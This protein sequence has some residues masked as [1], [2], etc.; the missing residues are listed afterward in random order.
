MRPLACITL[1]AIFNYAICARILGLF[2]HPGRSHHMV[3][4]SLLQKL[5]ERGHHVTVASFFP[6]KSPPA[7]YTDVSFEGITKIGLETIDLN[8]YENPEFILR[9]P[10]IG[11]IYKQ[12]IDFNPLWESALSVCSKAIDWPPLKEAL[13]KEYDVVLVE[14]FNSDCMIGLLHVYQIKAPVVAMLS[15]NL[16]PWSHERIGAPDNPSYVPLITTTFTSRMTFL[17]RMENTFLKLYLNLFYQQ[18]IQMKE[19]A[20]IEKHYGVKIP[21]LNELAKNISLMLT[22]THHA[23]NGVRPLVPGLVEVGGM[24]F[25]PTKKV[26]PEFIEKFLNESEHGVIIF[27]F[28]SLIKTATMPKY[29]EEIFINALSKL[30][31]RV[32][33]KFE[34]SAEEGTLVGNILKVKWLPQYELL[35]HKKVVAFIAHGGLLGMTE[36]VSAG[37]PMVVIPFY[38]DQPNNGASAESVGFAK[39]ISYMDLTEESLSEALQFVLSAETRL[40]ARRVSK[41]WHDR[42]SAPLDTA[43]YWVERVIRWGHAGKL[44]SVSRDMPFYEY[45]LLDVLAVYAL[46]VLAIIMIIYF[47]LIR[48]FYLFIKETKQKVH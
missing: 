20:M 46:I 4:E 25:N 3:F 42:E 45:L 44:H 9:I 28:G 33:W 21:E 8:C 32:I 41:M 47:L 14:N 15:S 26:I 39:V 43:I 22:N 27:S 29:K 34:H 35:H 2:P 24:H 16:L 36:A 19:R 11:R 13:S 7:N 30:K 10:I 5:P 18:K 17:E 31:Q 6:L 12:I 23:F 38:G 48:I 37:K 1:F 40:N